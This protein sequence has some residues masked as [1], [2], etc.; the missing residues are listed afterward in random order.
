[1]IELRPYQQDAYNK[2][3]FEY[4]KGF[5]APLLVMPTGAG[6]TFTFSY[7]TKNALEKGNSTLILVHRKELLYQASDSLHALGIEHGLIKSGIS[8]SPRKNVQVASKDTLVHRMHKYD[9]LKPRLI[10]IDEAHHSCSKTWRDIISYYSNAWLLGVTATPC[11]LDGRALGKDQGGVFDSMV[12]GPSIRDLINKGHLADFEIY[13]P[14]VGVDLSN[15]KSSGGDYNKKD[16]S[17][18]LNKSKIHGCVVQHYKDLALGKSAIAF[19]VSVAHAQEVAKEFLEAGIKAISIDGKTP[20]L[21]R[22]KAIDD[23]RTGKID[24]LTS[25]DIISEGTDIPKAEVA[26]LLRPTQSLSLFL[27]Q[28]GRVLRPGLNKKA[29]IIDHV[30][31]V[32]DRFGFPD[33][34]FNWSLTGKIKQGREIAEIQVKIRVCEKCF[35]VSQAKKIC[36][37]CGSDFPVKERKLTKEEKAELKQIQREQAR[38]NRIEVG[39]AQD[40]QALIAIGKKRGYKNPAGWAWHKINGRKKKRQRR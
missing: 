20:D 11:R 33:E 36:P 32:T 15:V 8:V 5:K 21:V 26:I 31:N 23:L 30:G 17:I 7:I 18:A 3:L 12:M 13:G 25:C 37:Y 40:M 2:L 24:V 38:Q 19:C 16:L 27:Q 39:Q 35:K 34:D 29:I 6:K 28:V 4:K 1:M 22:K 9:W 14:S 10:I